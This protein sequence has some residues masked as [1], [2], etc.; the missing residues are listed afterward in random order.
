M[1]DFAPASRRALLRQGASI[2]ALSLTGMAAPRADS[3]PALVPLRK[4]A[5]DAG[6]RYGS[7]SDIDVD[8]APP[9]YRALF[10]QQCAL[11][12]PNSTWKMQSPTPGALD[13]RQLQGTLAFAAAN[14]IK[15][16]GLHIYW[17]LRLPNWLED[18]SPNAAS[19]AVL[20]H[21]QALVASLKGQVYSW[22]VLNEE[23]RPQDGLAAGCRHKS[24]CDKMG[25]DAVVEL[26]RVA[27]AADPNALLAYNDSNFEQETPV[28]V[29]RRR[30]LLELI[31]VLKKRGAPIQAVG[32]QSHLSTD[33]TFNEPSFRR[34]LADIASRGVK[35][36]IT[37]LDVQDRSTPSDAAS[38]DRMVADVY[39]RYL[40]TALD[41]RAVASVVTWGLS[42]RYSWL[43]AGNAS[44]RR[45]DGLP[46]R[47]LPFDD[48]M[49]P[50]AAYYAILR[51]F[52]TCPRR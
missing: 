5:A 2:A 38:R 51:A 33:W 20:S 14:Q 9:E 32:L 48:A 8:R 15:L 46:Q 45:V 13:L 34:F 50:T 16:T 52:Q 28:N 36:L 30:A 25:V 41:E 19:A 17:Y 40:A 35:I 49:R 23:L 4:A 42:D 37:E 43:N 31:D 7:D 3:A 22:N 47:P 11:I 26:F 10:A 1:T 27:H 44:F 24:L 18:Q 6:L 12:A 29:G 21:T 39:S